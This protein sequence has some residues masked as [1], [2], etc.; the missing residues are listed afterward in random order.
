MHLRMRKATL[1][2]LLLGP[3]VGGGLAWAALGPA[4]VWPTFKTA[5]PVDQDFTLVEVFHYRE[6]SYPRPIRIESPVSRDEAR[7]DT[8]EYAFISRVSAMMRGDFDWWREVWAPGAANLFLAREAAQGR[9]A[10][11]W[12]QWWADSF[13]LTRYELVRRIET[14]PYVVLTYRVVTLDG[15]DATEGLELPVV[16]TQV[17]GTWRVSLDLRADPLVLASPWV[18]G[19]SAIEEGP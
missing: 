7:Y 15:K 11:Y 12:K 5:A 18:S 8:P 2:L 14:G 6:A 13:R 10:S 3:L 1:S 17:D 4:W 19:Q 9:D 16:M